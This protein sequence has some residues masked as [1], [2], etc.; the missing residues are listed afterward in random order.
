[1]T[2]STI[3][4]GIQSLTLTTQLKFSGSSGSLNVEVNGIVVGTIPYSATVATTTISNINVA[5]NVTIK[6]INPTAANRVAIDD[7]SWTCA[8]LGTTETAK[9][10]TF[11]IYPNPV[12]NNELFVKGE[13]LSRISKAEIYDLS[14]K[15][16]QTIEN[17][18]KNTNKIILKGIS[19]GNY[20]LKADQITTK[21]IVE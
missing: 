6:I 9:E 14:G 16:I 8:T 11:V 21:F 19:K 4:G 18:F 12:K 3:A 2:S 13:N 7:L 20:I 1:L 17:P 10:K 15:L 5:G